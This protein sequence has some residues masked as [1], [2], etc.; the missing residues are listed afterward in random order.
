[1]SV[2]RWYRT[3]GR[4]RRQGLSERAQDDRGVALIEFAVIIPLVF[5]LVFGVVDFGY[6]LSN[7]NSLR[8]GT[9][10]AARRAVVGDFGSDGTCSIDGGGALSADTQRLICMTKDKVGLEAS[11]TKVRVA[12]DASY[13][14]GDALLVCTQYPLESISGVYSSLLDSGRLTTRVDMRIE[15]TSNGGTPLALEAFSEPGDWSWCS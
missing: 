8:H 12:F 1:M 6:S 13:T 4:A 10:E 5:A 15:L 2:D 11:D 3:W 9:R 7:L 14:E